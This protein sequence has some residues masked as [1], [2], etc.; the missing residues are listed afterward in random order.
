V[1]D[2]VAQ[3]TQGIKDALAKY[4][5]MKIVAQ[6][7][8]PDL[9]QNGGLDQA[10]NILTAHP[11]VGAI[12]ASTDDIAFGAVQA[13]QEHH[14]TPGKVFVA[15]L[16]GEPRAVDSIKNNQGMSFTIS[17]KGVTWGKQ[18]IDVAVD[19]IHGKKP[20]AHRVDSA[21]Q[22][23]DTSNVTSLTPAQLQ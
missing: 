7:V 15:G 5:G 8:D 22:I 17:V 13:L 19:W 2:F 10:N 21:Y 20:A 14:I 12:L 11:D 1:I 18:A 6:G 9:S 16:D 23:V 4:P 3:S